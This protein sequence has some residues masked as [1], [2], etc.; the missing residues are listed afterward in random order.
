[1]GP[2]QTDYLIF[3]DCGFYEFIP[4]DGSSDRPLFMHELEE[5]K[6]YEIVVTNMSGLYRYKIRDIIRVTRFEGETPYI[7]FV[8]RADQITNL[9]GIHLN[10]EHLKAAVEKTG[11]ELGIRIT[12]YSIYADSDARPPRLELFFEAEGK[13]TEK[14]TVYN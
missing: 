10:G 9:C 7:E 11:K 14:D 5:G 1:M 12:D 4:V 3:P 8:Y 13:I 6:L 2:E